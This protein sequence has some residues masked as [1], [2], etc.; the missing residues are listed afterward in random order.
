MG[1]LEH[2]TPE[3]A[4]MDDQHQVFAEVYVSEGRVVLTDAARMDEAAGAFW[5]RIMEL[6]ERQKP[7]R[8]DDD[9][10]AWPRRRSTD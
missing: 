3:I 2:H 9:R 5:N 10:R 6:A 4:I 8:R 1:L 7:Q